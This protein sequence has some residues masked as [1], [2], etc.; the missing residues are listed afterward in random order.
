MKA[1][2]LENTEEQIKKMYPS[3]KIKMKRRRYGELCIDISLKN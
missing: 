3:L 2:I 1:T